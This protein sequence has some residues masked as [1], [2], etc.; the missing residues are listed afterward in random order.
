MI[1][2]AN[3]QKRI[4]QF[5]ELTKPGILVLLLITA[6]C[7]MFVAKGGMP[8]IAL[9]A[10]TLVG[11]TL[12]CGSANAINMVWDRDIDQVMERTSDRPIATGE[13]SPT[14]G[15]IFAISIG[16]IGTGILYWLVDPM[17]A[18]MGLSGHAFYVFIYTMWLK[19]RT[20]QNIVIGGAAGAF[21]PLIG[22]AA[23]TGEL[24][25]TAW[26]IFAVIFLWTPPHFWALAL[27]TDVDYEK[28]GI[29]MMPVA[30]GAKVTKYQM[31]I[32]TL[33]LMGVA[34]LLGV[35]GMM[36]IIYLVSSVILGVIFAYYA[37]RTAFSDDIIWAKQ[38]F[39]YSILYLGL[40][41]AAM[42]VDSLYT[43]HFTEERRLAS[44]KKE[45][46][47]IRQERVSDSAGIEYADDSEP[48]S[49]TQE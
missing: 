42:L 1:S 46:A 39:G 37:V 44:L 4:S 38:M 35:V 7:S 47:Q 21:P 16:L 14:V 36:G 15:L 24:S 3:I 13:I 5:I 11:T 30:Q 34:T 31:M 33:I 9:M 48:D 12:V 6:I 27:F 23:V 43:G 32:Y 22:W 40:L 45:A 25:L 18:W 8:S 10:W 49:E 2:A 17:A 20:P 28:A 26:L 29:P 41:F 19:R